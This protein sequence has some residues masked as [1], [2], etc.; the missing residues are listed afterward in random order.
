MRVVFIGKH[1]EFSLVSLRAI[2]ARHE[3]VAIVES[4]PRGSNQNASPPARSWRE[5]LGLAQPQGMR[6]MAQDMRVPH[7]WLT[8]NTAQ[9]F[10]RFSAVCFARYSLRRLA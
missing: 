4:G 8:R 1:H 5:W 2:Q 7:F 6:R 10:A 9:E 3:I